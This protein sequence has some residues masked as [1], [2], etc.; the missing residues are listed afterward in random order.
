MHWWVIENHV[1]GKTWSKLYSSEYVYTN[2]L[3]L[4][5]TC[6]VVC[7]IHFAKFIWP[8][9]SVRVGPFVCYVPAADL[10]TMALES[11]QL[12]GIRKIAVIARN[13]S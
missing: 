7:R 11:S 5:C 3:L 4:A 1:L 12:P 9:C 2:D 8:F 6:A 13:Y 10:R